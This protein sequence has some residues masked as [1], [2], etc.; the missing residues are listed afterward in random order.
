[1]ETSKYRD[2]GPETLPEVTPEKTPEVTPEDVGQ[3]SGG[4][5]NQLNISGDK[6][7][8]KKGGGNA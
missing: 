7:G 1:M 6:V 8:G 5:V 4:E 2:K 3:L